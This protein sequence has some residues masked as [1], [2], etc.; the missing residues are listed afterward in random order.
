[1]P[2]GGKTNLTKG[3]NFE[4]TVCTHVDTAQSPTHLADLHAQQEIT[5]A[6]DVEI[7]TLEAQILKWTKRTQGQETQT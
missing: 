4:Q 5:N 7:R 6:E 1:M 2:Y 3:R